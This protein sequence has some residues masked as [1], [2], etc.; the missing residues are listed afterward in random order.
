MVAAMI[1]GEV[2]FYWGHRWSHE[3]PLLWKFHV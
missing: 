2:G 3:L 1:V